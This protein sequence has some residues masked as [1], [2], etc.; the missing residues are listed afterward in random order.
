MNEDEIVLTMIDLKN[1]DIKLSC[2]DVNDAYKTVPIK[3]DIVYLKNLFN[4]SD[5]K[6]FNDKESDNKKPITKRVMTMTVRR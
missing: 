6:E 3:E 2:F 4:K 1:E 5:N